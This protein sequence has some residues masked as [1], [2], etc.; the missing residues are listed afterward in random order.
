MGR[1]EG[2]TAEKA[3]PF[4]CAAPRSFSSRSVYVAFLLMPSSGA[5]AHRGV[6]VVVLWAGITFA[7]AQELRSIQSLSQSYVT[8]VQSAF[9]RRRNDLGVSSLPQATQRAFLDFQSEEDALYT[10]A[11]A[12]A[13]GNTQAIALVRA[14]VEQLKANLKAELLATPPTTGQK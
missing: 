7:H 11:V 13:P 1:S 10:T 4:L 6:L 14:A 12:S 5:T 3:V 2:A 8:C 9:E